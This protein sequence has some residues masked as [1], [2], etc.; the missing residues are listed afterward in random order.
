[1]TDQKD[2][3]G[4]WGALL[5]HG[6]LAKKV[7]KPAK[8]QMRDGGGLTLPNR[9]PDHPG[10]PAGGP[11]RQRRRP[12]RPS[13]APDS[14]LGRSTVGAG[15]S[16]RRSKAVGWEDEMNGRPR[17]TRGRLTEWPPGGLASTEDLPPQHAQELI[18][19]GAP[20]HR[21]HKREIPHAPEQYYALYATSTGNRGDSTDAADFHDAMTQLMTMRMHSTGHASTPWET[22]EQPSYSFFYGQHPGT[23]TLNQWSSMASVLPPTIAL[24]DSGVMPRDMDLER[25]C[26]RLKELQSGLED[27]DEDLL[28]RILYKRMLKDPDKILSPHRTLD[29]QITDLILVLSR[30]DWIDFTN[31]RNQVVTRFIFETSEENQEQYQKFFHQL[32][33]SLELELRI[34]SPQHSKHA[35]EKLLHQIPPTIQWNLALARRWRENV[36]IYD[37]GMTA[38]ETRLRYKLKKRQVKALKRFAQ[39]MKWPNLA[40]VL[41]NLA[42]KD[43]DMCLDAI[44]SDTFAYFSGL[45]LPGVSTTNKPPIVM[46]SSWILTM[47]HVADISL[48][49]HEYLDRPGSGPRNG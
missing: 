26:E 16:G 21:G 36:R 18:S 15:Y 12:R 41:D 23:V 17:P 22:L 42:Q 11:S 27:D 19:R 32:L 38:E 35:K 8:D 4:F 44:S 20:S 48:S 24:R 13:P 30:P 31:P 43:E 28:Y 1:M 33:L 47:A 14:E 46:L 40:E 29:K 34:Q 45:V 7:D 6:S 2:K 25:I 5:R 10:G 39:I 49:H 9:R 37:W 3:K